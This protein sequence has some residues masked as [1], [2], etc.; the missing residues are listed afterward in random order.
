MPQELEF[1]HHPRRE[2][3]AGPGGEGRRER[4][5]RHE[6]PGY[7]PQGRNVVAY[8]LFF[9][10]PLP[11]HP[12]PLSSPLLPFCH[13]R[14]PP[15]SSLNASSFLLVPSFFLLPSSFP[16]PPPPPSP[17]S[18]P[19]PPAF[20]FLSAPLSH[21]SPPAATPTHLTFIPRRP[22]RLSG[23]G[24]PSGR[25]LRRTPMPP[26]ATGKG[27]NRPRVRY[28]HRHYTPPSPPRN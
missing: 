5:T 25:K 15:S 2:G 3:V 24:H 20:F 27:E 23:F 17:P 18:P 16:C 6:L 1:F 26:K 9:L 22:R 8:G 19:P 12:F 4:E 10:F 21:P 14:R 11:P 13:T 28:E 7:G